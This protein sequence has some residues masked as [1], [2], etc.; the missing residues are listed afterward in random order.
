G[1]GRYLIQDRALAVAPSASVYIA[2]TA[3]DRDRNRTSDRTALVVGNPETGG[4]RSAL[5]DLPEADREGHEIAALYP[6]SVPVR[7]GDATK[8]RFLDEFDQHEVVHFAGHGISNSDF[9]AL[10]RLVFAGPPGT[11]ADSLFAQDLAG[12][13]FVRAQVL[14]LAACQTS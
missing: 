12:R 11:G 5:S 2:A 14:V 8:R 4:S 7:A 9:P 6:G 10:S 3:A 1:T 13:R